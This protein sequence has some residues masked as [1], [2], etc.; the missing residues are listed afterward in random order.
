MP[1]S[2]CRREDV[3]ASLHG[4]PQHRSRF[5]YAQLS[6]RGDRFLNSEDSRVI[7]G[8]QPR[9]GV[10]WSPPGVLALLL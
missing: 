3:F 10:G 9:A 7:A 2:S 6:V 8:A 5:I 4:R 1:R